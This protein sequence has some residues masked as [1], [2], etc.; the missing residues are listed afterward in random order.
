MI[1][2][3]QEMTTEVRK[4]MRGGKGAVTVQHFMA[5]A[6]FK[7][8]VRLCARLT[9]PPGASIGMHRHEGEDEVYIITRGAAVLDDGT[10]RTP[11]SVGDAV[12]TGRGE[13]HA[14]AN[15]GTSDLEIT[16]VIVCYNPPAR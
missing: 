6:D 3:S 14:I 15:N 11:L 8:N 9:L 10:T 16:A 5:P 13:S 7:A 4:E 12:L 1:R 2:R